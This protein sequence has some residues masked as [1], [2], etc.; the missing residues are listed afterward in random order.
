MNEAREHRRFVDDLR[1]RLDE[2]GKTALLLI[3]RGNSAFFRT[4]KRTG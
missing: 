4:L 1:T 2:A 3:H